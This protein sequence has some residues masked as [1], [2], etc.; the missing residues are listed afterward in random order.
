MAEK[1]FPIIAQAPPGSLPPEM[2]Q[3]FMSALN[4]FNTHLQ[5]AEMKQANPQLIAQMKQAVKQA[6][7]HLTKG[8]N[9]PIPP[10]LQPAAAVAT[11]GA[12]SGRRVS[13]AQVKEVNKLASEEMP[14]QMGVVNT[15]ATPPKPPT[16]A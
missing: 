13:A 1:L 5:Q 12:P 16:A 3:P 2:I 4:H 11:G 15:V 14:S 9:V 10:E 7:D 8:Q 6:F